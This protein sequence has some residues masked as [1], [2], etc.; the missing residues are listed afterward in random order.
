[1]IDNIFP[2]HY[3][4]CKQSFIDDDLIRLNII[5][6]S[7]FAAQQKYFENYDG[8]RINT[9]APAN[10]LLEKTNH[11][12]DGVWYVNIVTQDG[13][14]PHFKPDNPKKYFDETKNKEKTIKYE[15]VIDSKNG[16]FLPKMTYRHVKLIADKFKVKNYPKGEPNTCCEEI[17]EWIKKNKKISI[18]VE[19][20]WKKTLTLC[21]MG[22]PCIGISG[23]YNFTNYSKKKINPGDNIVD[24]NLLDCFRIFEG[25]D[26]F[27]YYDMDKKETVIKNVNKAVEQLTKCLI[28]SNITKNVFRCY[29]DGSKGK[30]IDD[31]LFN[32]NGDISNLTYEQ[33][34]IGERYKEV[35]AD[36]EVNERYLTD[37]NGEGLK[38]IKKAIDSHRVILLDSPKNT[39]KTTF[40]SDYTYGFQL[41]G[42]KIF[43]PT[44]RR[45]LMAELSRKL[46][47][48]NAENCNKS[49]NQVFGLAMCLD[50]MHSNSSI[51]FTPEKLE[52]FSECVMVIDE[53]DQ[54]LDHLSDAQTDIKFHRKTVNENLIQLMKSCK[55]IIGASA[56]I[57]QEVAD[58]LEVNLNEKPFVIRNTYNAK[59]LNC[60]IYKHS[61]PYKLLSE[62]KKAVGRGEKI[63][64]FTTGQKEVSTW[65]TN[66]LEKYFKKEFPHLKIGVVDAATVVDKNRLE[67][68]C[69]EDYNKFIEEEKF[70]ILLVSPIVSTGTD[71][72]SKHFDSYWG[73]NW[74]VIS[75][76][77][78]AQAMGR[79]RDNI[80]R[81]IWSS[82]NFLGKKGNGSCFSHRLKYSQKN[83][84]KTNQLIFEYYNDELNPYEN[85]SLLNYWCTRAAIVNT[86]GKQ[87]QKATIEKFTNDYENI[88]ID[89]QD[90][91]K[92]DKDFISRA[93]KK[94]KKDNINRH[95]QAI[96]D[97][98]IIDDKKFQELRTRKEKTASD[99]CTEQ[100]N[101]IVRK[102][103]PE[104][105]EVKLT[106]EIIETENKG[107][108]SKLELHWLANLG[109]DLTHKL[110]KQR[111]LDGDFILDLN[112]KCKAIKINYLR[113]FGL[114]EIIDNPDEI[115]HND[116]PLIE[117]VA[118][119]IR[120]GFNKLKD[121]VVT[122]KDIWN[123]EKISPNSSNWILA[124]WALELQGYKMSEVKRTKKTRFY[125][126]VDNCDSK[127]RKMIF[128]FWNDEKLDLIEKGDK[129][130][131]AEN[132]EIKNSSNSERVRVTDTPNEGDKSLYINNTLETLSPSKIEKGDKSLVAENSEIKN[133]SGSERLRVTST[134]NKGDK[135]LYINNI[136][137]T[138]SPSKIVTLPVPPPDVYMGDLTLYPD[139]KM[140]ELAET[141]EL[142][143]D[144]APTAIPELSNLSP[145]ET[146]K[147]Q[148]SQFGWDVIRKG[149]KFNQKLLEKVKYYSNILLSTGEWES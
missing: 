71:I 103:S 102:I 147:Y 123:M 108:F 48:E 149:C 59:S 8:D 95:Y 5:S 40:L 44:H 41:E 128:D 134:P 66:T 25:H 118:S 38:S 47:T 106:P 13:I 37:K 81:H 129:S 24:F 31:Y 46:N 80:T 39:G 105:K 54:V 90:L 15:Q 138:L 122:I 63:M 26:F 27:L 126:L 49:I 110:D 64:V 53:I 89:D 91:G 100:A 98:P 88:E 112:K 17:W 16:Y 82:N 29:W 58:F 22:I 11:L 57:S 109:M 55:K 132:S 52:T 34:I 23:V 72:T 50:S 74:G 87:L 28:F 30:G 135:N 113:K 14:R 124:K 60:K 68:R 94:T 97:S 76:N 130:L 101:S 45:T 42:V 121:A 127:L 20:G 70:D 99:R 125:K 79:I 111:V 85:E 148:I 137:E 86:Q 36:L 144:S 139:K 140:P 116:H 35:K 33:I 6:L 78:F 18:A 120:S 136:L 10:R 77:T 107:Y 115:Y 56:D 62:A 142:I 92:G 12:L 1:M 7:G 19:E 141:L 69:C 75:V 114:S 146:F 2:H 119:R 3:Q 65:S 84:S 104:N 43:I 93:L 51:K 32:T 61:Q 4:E 143:I 96:I 133:S 9:G 117:K 83:E 67:Y 145:L 131:V 21:S 73:I